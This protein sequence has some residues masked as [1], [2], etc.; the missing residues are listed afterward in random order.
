MAEVGAL[1]KPG[2]KPDKKPRLGFKIGGLSISVCGKREQL[3]V[4]NLTAVFE[5]RLQ[6]SQGPQGCE[7]NRRRGAVPDPAGVVTVSVTGGGGETR[8]ARLLGEPGIP[9]TTFCL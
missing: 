6:G 4:A 1:L 3:T 8:P 5:P 7:Q 2:S 9:Q